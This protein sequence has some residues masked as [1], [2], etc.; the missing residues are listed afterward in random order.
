[1][2]LADAIAQ[3]PGDINRLDASGWSPMHWVI[4]RGDYHSLKVMLAHPGS[5]VHVRDV[6]GRT[7]L[8]FATDYEDSGSTKMAQLLLN[9]GAD[10]IPIQNTPSTKGVTPII[11]AF[12]NPAMLQLLLENGAVPTVMI[13]YE[14][15][16]RYWA[17]P[18]INFAN[19]CE[20]DDSYDCQ[21]HDVRRDD[22]ALSLEL[23][24]SSG[25]D[26]DQRD[27]AGMT[28]LCWSIHY[29]N[30]ALVHLLLRYGSK[31][32]IIDND[33][34]GILH[35]TAHFADMELIDILRLPTLRE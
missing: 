35:W 18:L 8:H 13:Q 21:A 32:D 6:S 28:A 11:S 20:R 26:I 9:A 12:H 14:G 27:A 10:A 5:N 25:V 19:G 3:D 34:W 4:W 15:H 33:G 16:L 17:T 2:P 23:L 29:L 30:R 31:T 22:W 1:M 7:L 24:I